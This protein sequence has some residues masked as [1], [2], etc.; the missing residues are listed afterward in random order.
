MIKVDVFW[1]AL[2]IILSLFLFEQSM[3][4]FARFLL[5]FWSFYINL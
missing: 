4:V 5:E 1:Y 3:N 2:K